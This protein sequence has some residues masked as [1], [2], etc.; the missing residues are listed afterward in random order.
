MRRAEAKSYPIDIFV[1]G[2]ASDA[3]R[4][5]RKHCLAVGLCVTVTP[6]TYVYTGGAEQGVRVGLIN[7]P[8]FPCEPETLWAKAE[9]LAGLLLD[10]LSQQSLTIQAPDRTL[11]LSRR[12]EDLTAASASEASP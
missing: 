9:L 1:A 4:F 11:W 10:G 3:E 5:C 12:P 7:Y 2:D 8:R 6:T